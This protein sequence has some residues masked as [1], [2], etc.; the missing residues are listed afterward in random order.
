MS[1]TQGFEVE[2]IACQYLCQ[3]GLTLL[4]ANYSCR[5]GEIDLIMKDGTYLVFI[6]VRAR[7]SIAFG[8][9]CESITYT[10]Q[11]KIIKTALHYVTKHRLMEKQPMR[12]DALIAEGNP[13]TLEWL[14]NAF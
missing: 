9:A 1:R 4:E 10:K 7:S 14:K 13:Y 2:K 11:Q 8:S 3:Q 5:F 12:F 6:E